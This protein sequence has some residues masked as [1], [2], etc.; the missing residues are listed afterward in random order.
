MV[1]NQNPPG[2]AAAIFWRCQDNAQFN[3]HIN[4]TF[5]GAAKSLKPKTKTVP[6]F[7]SSIK[8]KES[9]EVGDK[10]IK[11]ISDVVY[12]WDF[13]FW[14][15]SHLTKLGETNHLFPLLHLYSYG[16]PSEKTW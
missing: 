11:S 3:I 12:K 5:I 2:N 6:E 4:H 8:K 10:A 14:S 9:W 15:L 13:C 16:L 7:Q 1:K